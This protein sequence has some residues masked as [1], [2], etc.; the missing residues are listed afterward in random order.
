MVLLLIHSTPRQE[1]H[2]GLRAAACGYRGENGVVLG[3]SCQA[4]H[5][6]SDQPVSL[7][8]LS[9][10]SKSIAGCVALFSIGCSPIGYESEP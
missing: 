10:A 8:S 6:R 1:L 2:L 9:T 7:S 4:G 5:G 3:A